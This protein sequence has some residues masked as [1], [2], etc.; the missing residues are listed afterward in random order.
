MRAML[1][2]DQTEVKTGVN[3]RTLLQQQADADRLMTGVIWFLMLISFAMSFWYDTLMACLVIG[4][5][6][7]AM[8]TFLTLTL[9]GTRF[10]RIAV[11]AAFMTF[12]ALMI[13]Q[14]HGMIEF[15]FGI[16]VLLAFLL[17]Y[18][19]W[20]PVI[21]S[22]ALIAV[23]HIAFYVM[24]EMAMPVY[25]LPKTNGMDGFW[26]I[27]LHA[28][29]VVFETALL[30]YMTVKGAKEVR[31]Q[32][33]MMND[34]TDMVATQEKMIMQ[35]QNVSANLLNASHEITQ[36]SEKLSQGASEQA[37]SVEETSASLEEMVA[38]VDQNSENARLT[39]DMARQASQQANDSGEAVRNTVAAMEQIA[40]RIGIIEDIAYKTNLLALN[41][42]IEA[43]RAGE[44]GKGFAV[45][46]DEVRKL[47]E[48]SQQAA[49]D[50][51][52]V[53]HESLVVAQQAGQML[54]QM[55]PN[56]QKTATLVSEIAAASEEQRSGLGQVNQAVGQ[57]D[58]VAQQNASSSEEMA[59]TA[60]HMR[61][62]VDEL[63]ELMLA[64][65]SNQQ[66]EQPD[67]A[68]GLQ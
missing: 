19:D 66:E 26:I 32:E 7:V 67:L 68:A 13:H 42:A 31:Q 2:T 59:A 9:A 65:A 11:G 20:L 62:Q 43:A 21:T 63:Q 39:N 47:A 50:I 4:L 40:Q 55:V 60:E 6:S 41:A 5:P 23:H 25:V 3:F 30:V 48:R 51:I 10:S 58:T 37:A 52:S 61:Q 17:Q 33:G 22:A 28:V 57:L 8:P 14:S 12:S 16:F 1:N 54:A 38:T 18:R 15:H 64:L 29:F 24:Q 44:H 46:A 36:S 27:I 56:I 45:V 49:Q 53:S 35:A 34:M